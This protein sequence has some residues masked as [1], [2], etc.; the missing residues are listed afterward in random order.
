MQIK[1]LIENTANTPDLCAEHGLSLYI[2]TADKKILFDTGAGD[3]F[4]KNAQSLGIDLSQIDSVVLSHGH[5]DHGGGLNA[6]KQINNHAKIYIHPNACDAHYSR[7]LNGEQANIGI[8][9]TI[10]TWPNVIMTTPRH[11]IYPDAWLFSDVPGTPET[12]KANEGLYM[13]Q[14]DQLIADTFTHEQNLVI[15][16]GNHNTLITGCAHNGIVN[17]VEHYK[18]LTGS[19]PHI[20]IGGFHLTRRGIA[21]EPAVV[22]EIA[23][24]LLKTDAVY[25]TGHCTGDAVFELMKRVMGERLFRI[26]AGVGVSVK[27]Y[28]T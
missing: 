27:N 18:T 5:Y 2:K 14:N 15:Q 4:I 8:D 22:E 9:G 11:N 19:Y 16:T 3:A 20:V 1:T 17:I 28:L 10:A 24:A 6:F 7:R 26:R 12:L 21:E 25:Y 23:Y 13:E